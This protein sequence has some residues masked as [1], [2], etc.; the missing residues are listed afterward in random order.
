M[1]VCVTHLA[2]QSEGMGSVG[3]VSV[4]CAE[5]A[6]KVEMARKRHHVVSH[7][8]ALR[9]MDMKNTVEFVTKKLLHKGSQETQ[10]FLM[11]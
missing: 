10:N 9:Y 6:R 2:Q 8:H 3:A 5:I 4:F 7:R 1:C 11:K